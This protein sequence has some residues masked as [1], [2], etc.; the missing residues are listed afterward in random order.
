M[1]HI[2]TGKGYRGFNRA[3]G[4]EIRGKQHYNDELKRANCI[5][6]EEA[7]AIAR[8]KSAPKPY[9]ASRK[10][11]DIVRSCGRPDKNGKVRLPDRAIDELKRIG[12]ETNTDKINKHIKE[13]E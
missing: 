1:V 8:K 13:A 10:V 2:I 3:L 12:V 6:K 9:A 11:H 5:P 7:D 4:K